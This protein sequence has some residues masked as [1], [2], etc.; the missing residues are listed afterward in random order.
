MTFATPIQHQSA[1]VVEHCRAHLT[2]D[3]QHLRQR[4]GIAVRGMAPSTEYTRHLG[5]SRRLSYHAGALSMASP[6]PKRARSSSFFETISRQVLLAPDGSVCP[7]T[8]RVHCMV[9]A[10]RCAEINEAYENPA[11]SAPGSH[12]LGWHQTWL[13]PVRG[14]PVEHHARFPGLLNLVLDE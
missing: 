12:L 13:A 10:A 1:Q 3:V 9:P 11:R 5:C 2:S 7:R 14:R 8:S 6:S 4:H